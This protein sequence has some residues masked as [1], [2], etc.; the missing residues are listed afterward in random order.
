MYFADSAQHT[1]WA[2][3]YDTATGAIGERHVFA[4]TD[5]AE[6]PD[7]ATV[8]ADGYLWS[9]RY[10]GARIVRHAPDGRIDR[11]IDVP[12]RQVTSCAFGGADLSTLFI[13]S[14][15]QGMTPEQRSA[16]PL[17]GTLLAIEVGVRGL[18]EPRYAG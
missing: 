7:G 5:P 15:T 10:G 16:Q 4:R 9:V 17:A 12:A 1:I 8:D 2:F 13:T 18:P 6:A 11:V 3:P 14:A